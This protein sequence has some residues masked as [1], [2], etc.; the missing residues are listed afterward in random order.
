MIT[1]T[2]KT[3]QYHTI[4]YSTMRYS[5][6]Q[7]STIQH[8]TIQYNKENVNVKVFWIC[9]ETFNHVILLFLVFSFFLDI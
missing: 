7:Y 8:S 3:N 6:M 2:E 1:I 5:T 9:H 4:L